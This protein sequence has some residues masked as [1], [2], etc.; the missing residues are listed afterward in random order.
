M[1]K[2]PGSARPLNN[3][4]IKLAW[5]DNITPDRYEKALTLFKKSL[6]LSRARKSLE[7]DIIGNIAGIYFNTHQH[8]KAI[9]LNKKAL[10]IKPTFKKARYDLTKSLILL[11]EWE[12]AA[13]NADLLLSKGR[14]NENYFNLKGFI[15][16]WQGK[17]EEALTYFRKAYSMAPYKTSVL[18]NTGVA[19]SL[20]GEIQKA[21]WLFQQAAQISPEDVTTFFWLIENS[22]RAGDHSSTEKYTERLLASF[23]LPYIKSKLQALSGSYQ[24]APVSL[25]MITPIIRQKSME[26]SEEFENIK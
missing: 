6:S 17:P 26:M 7:A 11:G 20:I 8:E 3:L 14:I 22:L 24:S 1:L 23:S 21:E 13:E 5:G 9:E 18:V 16:L 2:A 15:L 19:L 25:S 4:A 12:E 10:K